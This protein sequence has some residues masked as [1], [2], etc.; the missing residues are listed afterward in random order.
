[1]DQL[2]R[3]GCILAVDVVGYS[4]LMAADQDRTYQR[5][6]DLR[7]ADIDPWISAHGGRVV[8]NTGDGFLALFD[9][10]GEATASAV[11]IQRT[12][13]AGQDEMT[14]AERIVLRIG[15]H[16]ADIIVSVMT[17]AGRL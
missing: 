14:E 2:H 6:T 16:A 1:V 10:P 7:A 13:L 15:V 9:T 12:V 17:A 5:L 11:D 4:R 8:K 3:Y